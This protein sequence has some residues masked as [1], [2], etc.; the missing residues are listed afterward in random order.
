MFTAYLWKCNLFFVRISGFDNT[1]CNGKYL[2]SKYCDAFYYGEYCDTFCKAADD[3]FGHYTCDT[4]TGSFI[5]D[6]GKY[7][8][9]KTQIV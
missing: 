7:N 6:E 2:K 4:T 5:C 9:V 3:E 1:N 8:I